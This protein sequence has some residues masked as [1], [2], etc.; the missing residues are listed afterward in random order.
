[1]LFKKCTKCKR[2]FTK[3]ELEKEIQSKKKKSTEKLLKKNCPDC[4]SHLKIYDASRFQKKWYGYLSIDKR[5][6]DHLILVEFKYYIDKDKTDS[7]EVKVPILNLAFET[8]DFSE[9]INIP[10]ENI[11]FYLKDKYE[12]VYNSEHKFLTLAFKKETIA[13]KQTVPVWW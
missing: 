13:E 10:D 7:F 5:T 4:G 11:S 9:A 3:E 8:K 2:E 12:K 6:I 1:M